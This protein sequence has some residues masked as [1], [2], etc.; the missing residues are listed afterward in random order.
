MRQA[1]GVYVVGAIGPA[2]RT[3]VDQHLTG[4]ARCRD[5]LAE[6][7]GLPALLGKVPADEASGQVSS[8]DPDATPLA[9][10]PVLR[11]AAHLRKPASVWPRL[12]AA[13]AAGLV[14]GA[15]ALAVAR[16]LDHPLDRAP[17]SAAR[18]WAAAV[19]G[20][21]L[22]THASAVIRYQPRPWGLELA[23]QVT[24]VR[25]GTRCRLQVTTAGGDS[26]WQRAA[27][28]WPAGRP[29]R[30]VSRVFRRSRCP[31]ARAFVVTAGTQTLVAIPLP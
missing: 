25:A 19:R 7:A 10:L 3:A 13:A 28:R 15:G 14:V 26:R 20:A 17:A 9:L 24:G 30:L 1:L 21:D 16:G 11:R 8:G 4:C 5:E 22:R 12:A 2:D 29:A 18:Q 23:V 31:H 6:L 27:G